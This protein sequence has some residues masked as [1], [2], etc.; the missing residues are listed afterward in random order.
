MRAAIA[1]W[2]ACR[3][4]PRRLMIRTLADTLSLKFS[5]IQFTPDLMP[6][7]ITGTEVIQ[8][9]KLSGTRALQVPAGPDLRQRDS[10]RRNQ[11]HAA[12][13]PG[14]PA[15][16]HAGAP[17]YRR[18]TAPSAGR[19][20]FRA[21]HAKPDRAG[22]HLSA[23][24]G[25]V[26]PLHVQHVRGLSQR[27]RR[28]SDRETNDGRRAGPIDANADRRGDHDLAADHPQG[29]G[30]RS[31][32]PLRAEVHAADA[33][34]KG[35]SAG[36]HRRLCKLGG[37][38]AREPVPGARGQGPGRVARPL[39]CQLRGHPCRRRAGAASSH[40]DQFQRR[41][42]RHQA[43]LDCATADR[44]HSRGRR[45]GHSTWKVTRSI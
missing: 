22:R 23:A 4:W 39:L 28:A 35:R 18:R 2:W 44:S 29:A 32:Q 30:G 38:A 27:R 20:V 6:S 25:A 33:A 21:G 34:R 17:G 11:S 3:A 10:G 37:R 15:G 41:S 24:R 5:R 36:L 1:C 12:E 19:A 14:R 9:D 13:D 16:G 7:D 43:G 26:G 8:E 31:R 42:G 40:H 45:R